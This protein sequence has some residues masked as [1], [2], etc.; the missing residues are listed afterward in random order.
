ML[1]IAAKTVTRVMIAAGAAVLAMMMFLTAL[2]VGLRYLFNRPLAGAFELVEYMMAILV[3]FCIV[4]CAYNKGHVAVELILGRFPR[5]V[6]LVVDIVTTLVTL[7]FVLT[8]AW[9]S[10]LYIGETY[11][12]DLTSAVLLIPT[13]PFVIPIAVGIAAFALNLMVHLSEL[14]SEVKNVGGND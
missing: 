1:T 2:D 3:P 10:F 12:A 13:Y 6:Q 8:I 4:Y 14:M 11:A 9:Q 7:L 5:R